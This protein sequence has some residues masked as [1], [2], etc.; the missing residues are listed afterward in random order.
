MYICYSLGNFCFAGHNNPDDKSS[1][2]FQ[3]RFRVKDG[4]VTNEGF[5]IIPIRISSRTE[6]NDFIP[7][8]HTKDTSIDAIL[9]ILRENGEDLTYA[10]KEYP[11][12]WDE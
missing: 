1:M 9:N 7:T 2:L 8:V 11:L 6:R 4:E 10:V 5:R 3:T 12:E